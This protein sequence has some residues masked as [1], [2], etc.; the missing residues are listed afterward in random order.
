MIL[1]SRIISIERINRARTVLVDYHSLT[2]LAREL[3]DSTVPSFDLTDLIKGGGPTLANIIQ[4]LV[5][6]D[7][8]I[9]D[10]LLFEAEPAVST[11]QELFPDAI[12]GVFIR[13]QTR[14]AIGQVIDRSV[15]LDSVEQPPPG[16]TYAEWVQWQQKDGSEKQ[17]ID[18]VDSATLNLVPPEYAGDPEIQDYVERHKHHAVGLPLCCTNSMM[19]LGRAH[20][21][22]ELARELGVPLSADPI[23]SRYFEILISN[24]KESLNQGTAEKIISF[25]EERTLKDMADTSSGLISVDLSIPAVAELVVN[26]AKT[27]RFSLHTAIIEIRNSKNAIKFREW[28]A[29]FASLSG[30]GRAATREKSEML[31]ELKQVCEIWK[32]DVR[33]Q[34]DYKS[35]KL[36]LDHIPIIGGFLKA[37]NWHEINFH[38]PR[39]LPSGKYPYFLFLNDLLRTPK[40]DYY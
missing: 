3:T 35:R 15:G 21:Y 18:R 7:N 8:I 28:C 10:S 24:L 5:L 32:K 22:L 26:L 11:A 40:Q 13:P 6:Y 20:F 34:V 14:T 30:Q 39:L 19:T 33:E 16:I 38:A 25:F 31:N 2:I 37:L 36:I 9:V 4:N 27:H 17:L 23:R 29:K 1:D 12:H